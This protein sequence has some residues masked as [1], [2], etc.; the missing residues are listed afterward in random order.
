VA[1]QLGIH[2]VACLGEYGARS[3]TAW[4][5]AAEIR[6]VY[7]YRA[8]SDPGVAFPLARRLYTRAWLSAEQPSVLF[9]LAT[10][11]LVERQVLLPGVSVLARLITRIRERANVRLFRKLATLPS[12]DQRDRLRALLVVPA[13]TR[14]SPP[15]QL[16]HGPTQPTAAG[17]VDALRRLRDARELGV[18]DLELSNIPAGRLKVLARYASTARAQAIQR[19]PAERGMATLVAFACTLEASAQ[20]GALDVLAPTLGDGPHVYAYLRS[21]DTRRSFVRVRACAR[22]SVTF[23]AIK[24]RTLIPPG[25]GKHRCA[26]RINLG[27]REWW[28]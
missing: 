10:A 1:A 20:D 8:F 22:R 21:L 27:S 2:D 7:G 24:C 13:G 6:R 23:E 12:A 17:L 26:S 18:D 4:E 3:N 19:M 14:R 16:R 15:D 5:H 28:C 25:G 11:W 9:D